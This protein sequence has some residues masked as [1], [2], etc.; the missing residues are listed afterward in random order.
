LAAV[1][2]GVA[3]LAFALS[4]GLADPPR[5]GPLWLFDDFKGEMG[6]WSFIAHNDAHFQ[7]TAGAL[8]AHMTESP[9][10]VVALTQSPGG[11]FTLEVAGAPV[12]GANDMAY[13]LVFDWQ[14]A[15]H[16]SAV[17]VNGNGYAEA[18]RAE[19]K[20]RTDWFVWGQWPHIVFGGPNRVRVD[21]RG[22]RVTV[23]V[24]DEWL[25]EG[26]RPAPGGQIGLIARGAAGEVVFSWVKVWARPE[27]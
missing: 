9:E 1:M 14:D 15:A 3:A 7:A 24:N 22:E 16:Y 5:A 13:G 26:T 6:R 12:N 27:R 8:I 18:Y 23:R 19:G 10:T 11:D 20:T 4:R 17:L 21:V 2:V 25:V